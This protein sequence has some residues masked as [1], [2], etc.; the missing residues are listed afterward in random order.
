VKTVKQ[1]AADLG[2]SRQAIY[3][4]LSTMQS[5]LLSTDDKGV[6]LINADGEAFLRVELSTK[7]STKQS[8]ELSSDSTVDTLVI[9]LKKELD[10]KNE[11]IR[12]LNARL[13]ESNAALVAAQQLSQTAQLLHAGTM[14]KQLTDGVV[15]PAEPDAPARNIFVRIFRRKNKC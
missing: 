6:T 14:Q 2:V 11:Q 1:V 12:E 13:A 3:K 8:M 15:A 7:Q 9:M 5:T 4:R 10:I